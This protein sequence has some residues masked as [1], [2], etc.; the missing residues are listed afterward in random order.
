M[1]IAVV[2]STFPALSETFILNQITGLID[3]G[4]DVDIYAE[5]P[6]SNRKAHPDVEKY[7]LLKRTYYF[8]R[9][10]SYSLRLMRGVRLVL[11]NFFKNPVITLQSLN[12]F[13]YGRAATSLALLYAITPFLRRPTYDI[14]HCH[15]GPNGINA[16]MLKEIG[17]LRGKLITTFHGYDATSYPQMHGKEAYKHLFSKGDIFTG[18]THFMINKVV[19]LG[20][21]EYKIIKHPVGVN[22]SEYKFKERT[23]LE[24][25]KVKVL[26][27]GRLVEKKGIEYSI[28][29]IAEVAKVFPNIHYS[30]VGDGL[31]HEQLK[32]LISDLKVEDT[33]K[34]LGWKTQDEVRQFYADSSIFVLSS[35]T[36]ASGD[37]EGQGLVLQEAQAMG[38]P[39]ISTLH[40]GIP[41]GVL[42]G[43]S[44]F[45]VPERDVNALTNKLLYLIE[46][47]EKWAEMGKAGRKFVEEKFDIDILNDQLVKIYKEAVNE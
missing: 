38:M 47:P 1:R 7:D 35:V 20:C 25:Q 18:G 12:A 46:H 13:Q 22:I 27:V 2:M 42:D 29:A 26:T 37:Q 30:I 23:L 39:V 31:L 17:I 33:V 9:P 3:R 4:H 28:R 41:D 15:F 34:L 40:N 44:G 21:P 11:T 45:L 10:E 32:K 19:A 5:R 36:T 24:N 8:A 16:A 6:S 43:E 14:I